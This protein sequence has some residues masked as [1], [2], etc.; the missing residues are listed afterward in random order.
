LQGVVPEQLVEGAGEDVSAK[1]TGELD[2]AVTQ[3]VLGELLH[4]SACGDQ[5]QALRPASV[6]AV[7]V[8]DAFGAYGLKSRAE[9]ERG[10]DGALRRL[11]L[12]AFLHPRTSGQDEYDGLFE[13]T[14]TEGGAGTISAPGAKPEQTL[15]KRFG[16]SRAMQLEAAATALAGLVWAAIGE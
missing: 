8:G 7:D 3:Q 16:P 12:R 9:V 2:V 11:L 10:E 15:V 1:A 4:R 5:L 14:V 13:L 6:V